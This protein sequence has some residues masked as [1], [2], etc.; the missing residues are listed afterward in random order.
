MRTPAKPVTIVIADD[1]L[2]DCLLM[3]EALEEN[4]WSSGIR[5]VGDGEELLEYLRRQGRYAGSKDIQRPA[6]ILLDL[7]MP[8]MDGREAL[9]K[10]KCDS[11]LRH[12]PVVVLTTSAT[13]ED[14]ICSYT[15]G[16]NSF[17]VKPV[18]FAALVQVM[19]SIIQYWLT[20]VSLPPHPRNACI[21]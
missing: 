9:A 11:R 14:I 18:T 13:D 15:L 20:T 8:R 2:D 21:P 6:L 5:F 16:A 7:N 3:R 1:D 19:N 17:I 10:I 12:I 4:G